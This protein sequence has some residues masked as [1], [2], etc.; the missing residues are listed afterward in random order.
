MPVL[1]LDRVGNIL[2]FI[3]VA[4]NEDQIETFASQLE[5]EGLANAISGSGDES[6][7]AIVL[8]ILGGSKEVDISPVENREKGL[9]QLERTKGEE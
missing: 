2:E 8:E 7:G 5:S 3:R 6:P 1:G 9:E 4:A